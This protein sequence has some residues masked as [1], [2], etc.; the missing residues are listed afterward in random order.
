M[1]GHIGLAGGAAYGA[2]KAALSAMTRS[3]AAEFS[4]AGV[5]VNTVAPGPVYTRASP[6]RITQLGA[7]T[8]FGR[9][10]QADEIA[11]VIAFVMSDRASYITG[12]VIPVD[13]GRTAIEPGAVPERLKQHRMG[14]RDEPGGHVMAAISSLTAPTQYAETDGMR[15]AYRRFGGARYLR[16]I[17]D[18]SG[19]STRS[20]RE[21]A[22][23][24]EEARAAPAAVLKSVAQEPS[25]LSALTRLSADRTGPQRAAQRPRR[26]AASGGPAAAPA[27]PQAGLATRSVSFCLHDV[28]TGIERVAPPAA[29]CRADGRP[30]ED[31]PPA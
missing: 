3:W 8:L 5:R 20:P 9:A 1:A 26:M 30:G 10:A 7:T 23:T 29:A 14:A 28:A 12:A 27:R 22:L 13:G 19:H 18:H 31:P 11:E 25:F 24:T 21:A 6:E 4:P 2:T 17:P 16:H 15:F